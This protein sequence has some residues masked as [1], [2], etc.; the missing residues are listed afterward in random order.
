M[1]FRSAMRLNELLVAGRKEKIFNAAH[2]LSQGGLAAGIAEMAL[3]NGVGAKIALNDPSIELLS[4]TP[5]RVLVAVKDGDALEAL[6]AR[7]SIQFSKLGATGGNSLVINSAEISLDELRM[8][9]TETL[10]RL[11]S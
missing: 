8:A 10:P 1:L 9:Y 2:D 3:K 5:G 4:E 7:Y 11:F 6:C